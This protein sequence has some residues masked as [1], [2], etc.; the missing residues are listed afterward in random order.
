M[1]G[2]FFRRFRLFSGRIMKITKDKNSIVITDPEC[3]SVKD[4]LEC[5]QV[6]RFG[7]SDGGYVLHASDKVCKITENGCEIK[8]I[9]DDPDFF[10]RY[11]ALDVDYHALNEKLCAFSELAD[12]AQAGKGI[13]LLRQD[14]FEMIISFIVSANNNIPRI[15][16]IIGRL[17]EK[18]GKKLSEGYAFPSRESLLELSVEDFAALGAGYRAQYL[19]EASR[20][21][22]DEFIG[23]VLALPTEDARKKLLTVKG[24]GPKVADCIVLFGLGRGDSFPVDT[25]IKQ[26]LSTEELDTPQKVHDYYMSRYGELSGL[27]QQYIFHYARNLG[28]FVGKVK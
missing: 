10:C 2:R 27:A 16:G 3:F 20:T 17:C 14:P 6:F 15:K 24:V 18:A 26:S 7:Q 22:T 23:E 25:W 12:A 5:G 13:R 4:T 11:F 21:V 8:I 28:S 9:T 1:K 19:Y